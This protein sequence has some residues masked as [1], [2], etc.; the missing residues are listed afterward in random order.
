VREPPLHALPAGAWTPHTIAR[1][2]GRTP[3][4]RVID[5]PRATLS[6]YPGTLR[7]LA[8][9]GLG[10]DEPTILITDGPDIPTKKVIDVYARR[11]NIEQRLAEARPAPHRRAAPHPAGRRTPP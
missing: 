5:D 6:A 7:Q 8:V 4:V 3:R 1:A 10:H 2:G 11:M 9:A